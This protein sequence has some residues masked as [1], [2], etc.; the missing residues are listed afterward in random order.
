M[1]FDFND[2][3]VDYLRIILIFFVS[4]TEIGPSID[5]II[6][7][8]TLVI[9]T[10]RLLSLL[11]SKKIKLSSFFKSI[12]IAI[13]VI[14]FSHLISLFVNFEL[15][16]ID[17][18][19]FLRLLT[20]IFVFYEI[21][22]IK[23]FFS[24]KY[25][26]LIILLI[27]TSIHLYFVLS[28]EFYRNDQLYADSNY[29][30][31]IYSIFLYLTIFCFK[32]FNNILPRSLIILISLAIIY[33]MLSTQSR[34][35]IV[36]ISFGLIMYFYTLKKSIPLKLFYTSILFL[37]VYSFSLYFNTFDKVVSRFSNERPSDLGAYQSRFIEVSSAVNV[38]LEYPE[39]ILIGTGPLNFENISQ[40]FTQYDNQIS[41]VHNTTLG[42]LFETGL[43]SLLAFLYL[44][45]ILFKYFDDPIQK[46]FVVY[47]F[48]NAQAIF[49]ISFIGFWVLIAILIST[50]KDLS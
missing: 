1:Y 23:N 9:V 24:K 27:F 14:L 6:F 32:A 7:G 25:F 2:I 19:T 35:G 42:V 47:A 20:Y 44:F 16:N 46:S 15:N 31:F 26:I 22:S 48:I 18:M 4:I 28:N 40:N 39:Y 30:F 21:S 10:Y 34:G 8:I 17:L 5:V 50:K 45:F 49:V 13:S 37:S 3:P 11:S 29:L 36:A 43:F 12:G 33:L 41:R 38:L